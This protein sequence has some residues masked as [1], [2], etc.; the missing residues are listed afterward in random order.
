MLDPYEIRSLFRQNSSVKIGHDE[1]CRLANE[2]NTKLCT[3]PS[4]TSLI[5]QVWSSNTARK[6][7]HFMWQALSNCVPVCSRLADWHCH[8]NRTC[9]RCGHDDETVNHMLFECPP[10]TQTWALALHLS[11]W[12]GG[13]PE[14]LSLQQFRLPHKQSYKTGRAGRGFS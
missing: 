9:Q 1:I 14:L 7:K 11:L 2:Q 4:V 10:A 5:N 8:S 12:G 13:V 3:E 6:I